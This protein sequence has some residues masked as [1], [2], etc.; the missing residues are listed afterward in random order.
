MQD[1][2]ILA[3]KVVTRPLQAW[4]AATNAPITIAPGEEV[5]NCL[6]VGQ[7][8]CGKSEPPAPHAAE[9]DFGGRRFHTPLVL[10][11]TRTETH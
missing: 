9:F 4:D 1:R 8:Q 11:Q 7:R 3:M 5:R 10:F 6:V 2:T